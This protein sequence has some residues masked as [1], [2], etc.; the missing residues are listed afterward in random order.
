MADHSAENKVSISS[1]EQ[2]VIQNAQQEI[3]DKK[4]EERRQ[5]EYEI[6]RQKRKLIPPGVMLTGG[7]IASILM[8]LRGYELKDLIPI[9]VIVLVLFYI[10]GALIKY[11]FDSFAE[12][13]REQEDGDVVEKTG[14]GDESGTS[15]GTVREQGERE[16]TSDD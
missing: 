14:G 12:Q 10:A 3:I 8:Y 7:A 1:D 2:A 5:K 4:E 15:D 16:D 6:A 13:I 9:L 11:M